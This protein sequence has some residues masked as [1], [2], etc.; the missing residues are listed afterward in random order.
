MF[1]SLVNCCTIDW[2]TT[3]PKD[4]LERVAGMFLNEMELETDMVDK[5]V[6]M[7]QHFHTSIQNESDRFHRE[8]KR[9]TYVTPTSYLELI[10]T[11]I[12]FHHLKVE[13]ITTQR[14][15]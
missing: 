4:A 1:P 6:E 9:R 12:N 2:F 10:H 11:F 15:R 8:Q 13:Q 7:C 14:N 3:W 5:C